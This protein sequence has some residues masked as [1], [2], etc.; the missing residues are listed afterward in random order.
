VDGKPRRVDSEFHKL[1][2]PDVPLDDIGRDVEVVGVLGVHGDP[3][4][5]LV[6]VG[7]VLVVKLLLQSVAHFSSSWVSSH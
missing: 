1:A 2:G 3:V 7:E 4:H 6:A 5:Q